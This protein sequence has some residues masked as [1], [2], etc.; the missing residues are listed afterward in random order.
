[1]RTV[2]FASRTRGHPD[3]HFRIEPIVSGALD[4]SASVEEGVCDNIRN[5]S[6]WWL[7]IRALDGIG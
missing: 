2:V 1:M 4:G 6:C 3:A 5:A 7:G